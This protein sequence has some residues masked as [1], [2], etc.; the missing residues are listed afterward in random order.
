MGRKAKRAKVLVRHMRING[1]PIDPKIADACGV[2]EQNNKL[3]REKLEAENA[4]AVSAADKAKREEE[5]KAL[6]AEAAK[7]KAE[8]KVE[9]AKKE[10]PP[11]KRKA[12]TRRR[13]TTAT[14][15]KAQPNKASD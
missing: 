15:K 4:K 8:K 2:S 14:K 10:E 12:P 7:Q 1:E 11:K 13:K 5:M 9:V 3:I 6:A